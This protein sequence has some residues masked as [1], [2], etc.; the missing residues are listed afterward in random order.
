MD[1][2]TTPVNQH[3]EALGRPPVD[4]ADARELL[5]VETCAAYGLDR[6]QDG[7]LEGVIEALPSDRLM[8]M[9]EEGDPNA[10]HDDLMDNECAFADVWREAGRRG[11]L[12][13]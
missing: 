12:E 5:L 2:T 3:R 6:W 9:I 4:S 1:Q 10:E 8:A 11:L 7:I 13:R